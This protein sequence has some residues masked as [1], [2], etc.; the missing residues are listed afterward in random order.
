MPKTHHVKAAPVY[1]DAV[2]R[3]DKPFEIRKNDR[4]FQAG[5]TLI[6]EEWDANR[7]RPVMP[8]PPICIPPAPAPF[9]EIPKAEDWRYTGQ[10]LKATV[11]YVLHPNAAFTGLEKDHVILGLVDVEF[12]SDD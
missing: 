9:S 12:E 5:D 6:L 10:R 1:F 4:D 11:S 2:N 3:G 7:A 8:A